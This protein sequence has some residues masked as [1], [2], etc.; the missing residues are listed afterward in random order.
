MEEYII[1]F[2]TIIKELKRKNRSV[3]SS[4]KLSPNEID[5][6]VALDM[7]VYDKAAEIAESFEISKSLVCRSVD[8]LIKKGY[9][10]TK[11]DEK[12]KRI[13]RLILKED[14]KPIVKLLKENRNKTTEVILKGIDKDE[15]AI[16]NKVLDKMKKNLL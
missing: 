9:I 5:I 3:I 8:S 10:D 6:L 7:E 1:K 12:D 11:K 4:Y 16:F 14:A 15:L 2:A 13:T